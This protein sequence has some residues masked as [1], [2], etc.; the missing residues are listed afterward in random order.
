MR[1]GGDRKSYVTAQLSGKEADS[2][3]EIAMISQNSGMI[4]VRQKQNGVEVIRPISSNQNSQ[5][6]GHKLMD[7]Q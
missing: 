3:V 1:F 2:D 7:Y 5:I 6:D 4:R